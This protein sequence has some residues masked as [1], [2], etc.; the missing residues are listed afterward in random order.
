MN[1]VAIHTDFRLYWPARLNALNGYIKQRGD[2]FTVIEIAGKG[3]PYS[4]AKGQSHDGLDW[5]VLFPELKPEELSGKLIW[6]RL[7]PL[8][9][10]IN[11][12]VILSGAIAFPSGALSV[13][14]A[15]SRKDKRVVVFDDAKIDAV[16]RNPLVNFIKQSVYNGVDAMFYPSEKWIETGRFWGFEEERMGF[17]V[18]VVDN[19]FW[20]IPTP[21]GQTD[22]SYFLAVGRQIP[23]KNFTG[24]LEAYKRYVDRFGRQSAMGLILVGNGPEQDR[25]LDFI[26]CNGL[27]D[28]ITC[29][30]F[31]TPEELRMIYNISDVLIV[32]SN[33]EETWG[34]V[35]NEAMN[36]GCAIIASRECGASETLIEEGVNGFI[37]SCRDTNTLFEAMCDYHLLTNAEKKEMSEASRRI[38]KN[39]G[40]QKF[41]DGAIHAIDHVC[42]HK[43]RPVNIVNSIIISL[44]KGQYKPV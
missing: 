34:L 29:H 16:K 41:V 44:W 19:D 10:R 20:S 6:S 23:K 40:L 37:T 4:F 33:E 8:F 39:W 5:I 18:D 2:K 43:K 35:I 1:I 3:S 21:D 31:K 22:K 42:S 17:G 28:M 24:I 38:I 27:S 15:N 7:R 9:D 36:G 32:N 30:N 26:K 13:R 14:W 25:I 11:P 12:D